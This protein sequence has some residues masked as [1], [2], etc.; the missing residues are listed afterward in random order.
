MSGMWQIGSFMIQKEWIVILFAYLLAVVIL[1]YTYD[2]P[3]LDKK[4]RNDLRVHALSMLIIVYQLAPFIYEINSAIRDPL[5]ILARPGTSVDWGL[6]WFAV[7]LYMSFKLKNN[8]TAWYIM[9]LYFFFLYI[10]TDFF[11]RMYIAVTATSSLS[12][13][14]VMTVYL[15]LFFL[16]IALRKRT[17]PWLQFYVLLFIYSGSMIVV[18]LLSHSIKMLFIYVSMNWFIL[19]L[20]F[21]LLSS[22]IHLFVQRRNT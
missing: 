22:G 9:M 19:L 7:V 2:F 3:P 8:Q 21:V 14:I 5:S 4:L 11:Y 6:A 17:P 16:Y 1:H 10:F 20:L 12:S 18:S 15:V 13:L